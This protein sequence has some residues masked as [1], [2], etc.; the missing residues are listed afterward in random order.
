MRR[1]FRGRQRAGRH[2]FVIGRCGSPIPTIKTKKS[3][4]EADA[5]ADITIEQPRFSPDSLQ[6]AFIKVRLELRGES[7]GGRR[8]DRH[9]A[10]AGFRSAPLRIQMDV[11]W[12][13]EGP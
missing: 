7:M 8:F 4:F 12:I 11:G 1:R 13:N 9:G 6:I 3:W 2:L 10:S 5:T